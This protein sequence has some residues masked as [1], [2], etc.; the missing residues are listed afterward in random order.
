MRGWAL[1]IIGQVGEWVYRGIEARK[2]GFVDNWTG[3]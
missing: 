1:W 2:G 3:W